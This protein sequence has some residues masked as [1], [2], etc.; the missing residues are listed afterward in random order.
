MS[1]TSP[2]GNRTAAPTID[3]PRMTRGRATAV[4]DLAAV[5]N[6][7]RLFARRNAAGLMAVVK[8][9]GFGHGAV[10]LA[11]AA[12]AGGAGWL[13]V[14]SVD[15]ALQL[16]TAGLSAPILSWLNAVDAD[17][18][19]ALRHRV[20]LA[21]PGVDHLDAVTA[22]AVRTGRRAR[23]HLHLDTGMARDGAAAAEW[24]HLLRRVAAAVA[25]GPVQLVGVMGHLACADDPD[26]PHNPAGRLA[27]ERALVAVRRA[28][29]APGIRHLATTAATLTDPRTHYD[30]S[31]IGAGLVGIDPSGGTALLPT[32]SLFAPV[33]SVRDVPAGT[34]VGYRH[35]H[36]TQRA[37]RLA[38]LPLGYADGIPRSAG[39]TGQVL[40]RGRRCRLV[41]AVSMDQI[42]IDVGDEPVA[43]GEVATVFGPGAKGEPTVADWA[44]WADTIEQEIVARIG[45]RIIRTYVRDA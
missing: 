10:P 28:G 9:D 30:L 35:G 12:L 7:A 24:P 19:T 36:V 16:R 1:P 8:A 23:I 4:V 22:A 5:Q 15:E 43:P 33:V 17:F 3:P 2:A 11:R 44:R 6:N 20:D 34:A 25:R 38:L 26:D 45:Q 40:L 32:M 42:V 14:T 21:V 41:G 29:L 39:G 31:R 13:G 18:D 27:F 37:T